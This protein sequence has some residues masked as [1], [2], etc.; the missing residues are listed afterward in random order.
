MEPGLC[1]PLRAR[2]R[3]DGLRHPAA[4]RRD[5]HQDLRLVDQHDGP[6]RLRLIGPWGPRQCGLLSRV[7]RGPRPNQTGH[8]L[9]QHTHGCC[10]CALPRGAESSPVS[11]QLNI[12]QPATNTEGGLTGTCGSSPTTPRR[13]EEGRGRQL[14]CDDRGSIIHLYIFTFHVNLNSI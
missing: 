14:R 13:S 8:R 9:P 10:C 2:G 1:L 3:A 4:G 7:P 12:K 11:R 6:L 5:P